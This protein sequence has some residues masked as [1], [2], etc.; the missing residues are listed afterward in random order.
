MR[1]LT[2]TLE[3]RFNSLFSSR[4][5]RLARPLWRGLARLNQIGAIERL[6]QGCRHLTGLAFV[7]AVLRALDCRYL[8]DQIERERIPE[9][10]RCLIVANHPLGLLD[11]L[12]LLHAVGSVRRDLCIVAN[13]ALSAI[14]NLDG[15]LLPVRV[16]QGDGALANGLAGMA[17]IER[18]LAAEKAVIVLPAGEISR[19]GWAGIR[20]CAWQRGF[21]RLAE[22]SAA[23]LLPIH[24]SGR[25]SMAFYALS[26]LQKPLGLAVL[27]RQLMT[28]GRRLQLRIGQPIA[29]TALRQPA[30]APAAAA[31]RMRAAVYALAN[32]RDRLPPRLQ[33]IRHAPALRPMLAEVQQLRLLGNTPDGKQIRCG[34]LA[35]D[36]LLLHEIAR[37]REFTFRAVG[38]GSG[39]AADL[40]RFDRH[41]QQLLLWDPDLLEVVGAYRIADCRAVLA[42]HG[43]S[44]LY[45]LGLF[46][47]GTAECARLD[48]AM[49]L[50]RSFVQPKYWGSR[51]LDYLWIGIGAWLRAHPH[52][53][54]LFGA[55]SISAALPLPAR[56][57]LVA[58]Y[59]HYYGFASSAR[60]LHP[61]C[62]SAAPPTFDGLDSDAGMR[63]L[64]HNL[65]AV[66]ARVP[67][68]Y[69]QYTELCEPGGARFLAFGVDSEFA[70]SLDGLIWVDLDRVNPKKRQRYLSSGATLIEATQA[71]AA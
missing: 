30:R 62:Y 71:V 13:Q 57:W 61:F 6:W 20:D 33:A 67:T 11:A 5:H 27:G 60:A 49:E 32:G 64:K 2:Q 8:V 69:K 31:Q 24:V 42:E 44:G 47:L 70:D 54:H 38:E 14:D 19:L 56:E 12:V 65:A 63:L 51:S 28:R 25:N 22:R 29:A 1:K 55:V 39:N 66:G 48:Q 40:D 7:D 59:A 68:L 53:R 58:Y 3:Q 10:G 17:A 4:Q 41:Y 50:G 36:S 15:L 45:T 52:V 43:R 9:Q 37:L 35:G 21:V 16:F 46:D 23:G 26:L 34:R 18:A